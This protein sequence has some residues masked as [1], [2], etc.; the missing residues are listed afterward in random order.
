MWC[1]SP[2]AGNLHPLSSHPQFTCGDRLSGCAILL[3]NIQDRLW[4]VQVVSWESS[5]SQSHSKVKLKIYYKRFYMIPKVNRIK[6]TNYYITIHK[7]YCIFHYKINCHFWKEK[8]EAIWCP[9]NKMNELLSILKRW[10]WVILLFGFS[11]FTH[12]LG[13]LTFHVDYDSVSWCVKQTGKHKK[14]SLFHLK[15]AI[16][17]KQIILFVKMLFCEYL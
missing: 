8:Y 6:H 10:A 15:I 3:L 2:S 5:L 14:H 1:I 11:E 12:P 7:V 9:L 16:Y 17:W 4:G 13:I